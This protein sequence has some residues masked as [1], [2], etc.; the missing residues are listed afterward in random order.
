[1]STSISDFYNSWFKLIKTETPEVKE[2]VKISQEELDKLDSL[3]ERNEE[4][5]DY[6]K[7]LISEDKIRLIGIS[8]PDLN[9]NQ[10]D[11]TY[12]LDIYYHNPTAS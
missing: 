10:I 1:M 2:P 5:I 11:V 3:K 4:Y 8:D 9:E 12:K 6:L 7:V